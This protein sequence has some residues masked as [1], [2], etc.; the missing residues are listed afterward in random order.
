L[1][2][3]YLP[4]RHETLYLIPIIPKTNK[5]EIIAGVIGACMPAIPEE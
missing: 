1:V 4:S 3:E 5:K 2:V